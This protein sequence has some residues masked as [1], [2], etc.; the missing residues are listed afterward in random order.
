MFGQFTLQGSP[1]KAEQLSGLR[2]IAA[3]IGQHAL[4]VFPLNPRKTGC[5]WG[6]SHGPLKLPVRK[7]SPPTRAARIAQAGKLF[8]LPALFPVQNA[9]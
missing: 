5:I 7:L 8:S 3:A 9:M 1:V 6:L 4:N 2:D